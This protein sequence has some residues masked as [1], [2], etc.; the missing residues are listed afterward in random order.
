MQLSLGFR[1]SP[2]VE[3]QRDRMGEERGDSLLRHL[4]CSTE[5]ESFSKSTADGGVAFK[6]QPSICI[7]FAQ[8]RMMNRKTFLLSG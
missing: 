5:G 4:T 7:S 6:G 1:S 2:G 8:V 3:R